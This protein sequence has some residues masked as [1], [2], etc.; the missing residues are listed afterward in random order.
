[1]PTQRFTLLALQSVLQQLLQGTG[2]WRRPV[3]AG[4]WQLSA[5]TL[6]AWLGCRWQPQCLGAPDYP[7]AR[8]PYLETASDWQ[9]MLGQAEHAR[10]AP[11]LY[12]VAR[13][14]G[15]CP[16]PVERALHDVYAFTAV[17]NRLR[18]RELTTILATLE[19]ADIPA[20]VL[21]GAA[22]AGVVYGDIALRPMSDL[23][24][25][26]RREHVNLSLDRFTCLGWTVGSIEPRTGTTLDYENE[27]LLVGPPPARNL[28]E[29]HWDLLDS[30]HHQRTIDNNWLWQTAQPA[31]LGGVIALILGPEAQL[32]HLC[33]HLAFHHGR[34]DQP[35]LLWQHDVAQVLHVYRDR[36]DWDVIL[37][38]AQAFDLVLPLQQVLGQVLAMWS[39]PVPDNAMQRL[40]QLHPSPAEAVVFNGSPKAIAQWRNASGTIY[41]ACPIGVRGPNSPC[42]TFFPH[43]P[44][45]ANATISPRASRFCC[46]THIDGPSAFKKPSPSAVNSRILV[47]GFCIYL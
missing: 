22:L 4:R 12:T 45:C 6:L 8:H 25:L 16:P 35:V 40:A 10:V 34:G 9:G 46:R 44:T 33:A 42:R 19:V 39:V 47:D 13:T 29:I 30:P 3:Q 17:Q 18:L 11:L 2:R 23:D 15:V 26:V 43:Q 32:L 27:L 14:C 7:D 20:I 24:V 5:V 28:L 36:L 21:K 31:H 38:K 1:M 37:T 41:P